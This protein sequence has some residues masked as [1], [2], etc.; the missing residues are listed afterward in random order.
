[1]YGGKER[2][3]QG[4]GGEDLTEGSHLED[5]GVDGLILSFFKYWKRLLTELIWIGV[6]TSGGL[7]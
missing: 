1:M 7:L 4:F 6:R 2:C 3:M 5:L